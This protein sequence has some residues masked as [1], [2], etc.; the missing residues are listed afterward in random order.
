MEPRKQI[1]VVDDEEPN[2]VLLEA[3][4]YAFG[5]EP[6]LACDGY[7]ALKRLTPDID[8]VLMD[9]MMPGLDGYEVTRR[10]R[11]HEEYGD[12]PVIMVTGLTGKED[13]L[14]AVET[15]ANDFITKP[16]DRVEL[17]IRIN[18]L[19]KMKEAQDAI[20][21]HRADLE[22]TVRMRTA[23]LRETEERYRTLFENSLDAILMV[24]PTGAII[25]G[26]RAFLN[27]LGCS[28][29][30][31]ME[32]NALDRC[33]DP[34][35]QERY[36]SVMRGK[37]FVKDLEIK[38]RT[39][40]GHEKCCLITASVHKDSNG[41][42]VAYQSIMR[43]VTDKKAAENA[44]RESEERMR[45]LIESSPIAIG[46]VREGK[47]SYANPA[48]V[49]MFG[50]QDPSELVGLPLEAICIA[51]T[52]DTFRERA[53]NGMLEATGT[54]FYEMKALRKDGHTLDVSIWL[55]PIEFRGDPALLAF[56][57]DVSEQKALKAQLLQS[58]KMEALGTLAG[59]IA[60]DFNNLLFVIMGFVELAM[61][62]IVMGSRQHE[63]LTQVLEA[64]N[65]AK[66]LVA[67]ILTFSRQSEQERK[68]ID[69]GPIVKETVKFLRASIPSTIEIRGNVAS[70]LGRILGDPTQVHQVLMN[71]CTNASHA[72]RDTGGRLEVSLDQTEFRTRPELPCAEMSPGRYLRLIVS[73]TGH[74][75]S[76]DMVQRIFEPYFTTKK[77][78]E[79]TGLG[80]AVVHGIVTGH[81]GAVTVETERGK[82]STFHVY[83]PVI[84]AHET[85]GELDFG[86]IP[87]G[88]E[89][90][91]LVDDEQPVVNI[92]K[93]MLERLGYTVTETTDSME[94]LRLFR[95]CPA[96]FDLVM[97]D[98]TMPQMTGVQLL[99]ALTEIRADI[100][101]LLCTGY[102]E[103]ITEDRVKELGIGALV[104]KP[105]LTGHL[106]RTIRQVLDGTQGKEA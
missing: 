93:Q 32:R 22:E 60:H 86:P 18:S 106:A 101:T 39:L 37:G 99:Q 28:R 23:A 67:Q 66:D 87:F 63:K 8:L 104:K 74:G 59:G 76:A 21:R 24:D 85:P 35:D 68:P 42:L 11:C 72:M 14:R 80:L 45:V 16:I 105:V 94:A 96:E 1:L 57:V 69:I 44:L 91:L 89:R 33:I 13:R 46:I 43:D 97:S 62:E 95:A 2:R 9:V 50:Y 61:D 17:R 103:V 3:I 73:D 52:R 75:I 29:D 47:Y 65:R 20:K 7:E 90:V 56:L 98:M 58:Q 78:G 53:T 51:E 55:S 12:V 102:S 4:L 25:E 36:L 15:G 54:S 70:K 10:I 100:P 5:Y 48:L 6:E 38:L 31:V 26:N 71:L 64:A 77:Q 82:G 81:G 88:Q 30:D 19:L 83:F 49:R 41:K 92:V 79:G 84:R 34:A 40:D 27:L